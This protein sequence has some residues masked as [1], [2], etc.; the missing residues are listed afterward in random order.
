MAI[1]K[2]DA[3]PIVSR[4]ARIGSVSIS[5]SLASTNPTKTV[6]IKKSIDLLE[7]WNQFFNEVKETGK[8]F[9]IS[10]LHLKGRKPNGFDKDWSKNTNVNLE[11]APIR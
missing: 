7:H 6:E 3:Y 5:L 4:C 1:V 11:A 2:L 10:A 8:P 9:Q